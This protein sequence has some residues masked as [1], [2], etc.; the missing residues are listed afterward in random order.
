[1]NENPKQADQLPDADPE[2]VRDLGKLLGKGQVSEKSLDRIAYSRDVWPRAY[3]WMREGH[4]P[5]PPDAVVWPRSELEVADILK[6]CNEKGVAVTPA[7][8]G[9]GV[10]GGSI[11][12]RGGIVM[13]LKR[14]NKVRSI[15]TTN[16]TVEVDAGII[17]ELLERELQRKGFSLGHF[18]AS[19][20]CSTV[21]GWLSARSAGQLSSKYGKIEDMV[22]SLSGVFPDG[23]VFHSRESPRSAAGPDLDQIVIGSEGTLAVITRALLAIHPAPCREEYRGYLFPSMEDGLEAMR[24][25]MRRGLDP[26]VA[27][28][29]DEFETGLHREKY[30]VKGQGC[31]LI[32]GFEGPDQPYA[33]AR[34][35]AGFEILAETGK[36]LGEGPGRAWLEHR[37]STSYYQ[38]KV[39]S[40]ESAILDTCEVCALWS[41]VGEVLHGVKDAI[42]PHALVTAHV[43]H[44]Y[45]TGAAVYFTFVSRSEEPPPQDV[46]DSAWEAAMQ[47]CLDSG[48]AISHHHG[49]GFHKSRWMK[50]QLGPLLE[51]YKGLKRKLDPHNILNPGKLG[52]D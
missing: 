36:D 2:L 12:V 29:Y 38:S 7:G 25:V 6:L 41:R 5:H 43:S 40:Q 4:V 10:C 28:L 16:H 50:S 49:V 42:S 19:M 18:P 22:L 21:G 34:A 23:T 3:L 14:M 39:L 11:P 13:D 32:A 51:V 27:R 44:L 30:G 33:R 1:M 9:S 17:G 20:Y 45:S 46:Y 48:A 26:C 8:G 52:L 47:A 31:L 15:N 35:K 37:Y 24:L